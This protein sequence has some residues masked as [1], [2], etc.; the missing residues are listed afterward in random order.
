[1]LEPKGTQQPEKEVSPS[2]APSSSE[3][4]PFEISELEVLTDKQ[5]PPPM[6][7]EE[8]QLAMINPAAEPFADE[9]LPPMSQQEE[10][11]PPA[12]EE[13]AVQGAADVAW[14]KLV[15]ALVAR[16]EEDDMALKGGWFGRYRLASLSGSTLIVYLFDA[17]IRDFMSLQTTGRTAELTRKRYG[18]EL[19][20]LWRELSGDE[21]ALLELRSDRP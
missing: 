6:S 14:A 13:Q 2:P 5:L 18:E 8:E 17:P 16:H 3:G 12:H 20:A 1:M 19:S 10:S 21:E 11:K 15:E 7:S 9:Q 4:D